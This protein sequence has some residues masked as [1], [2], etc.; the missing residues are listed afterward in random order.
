MGIADEQKEED[1]CLSKSLAEAYERGKKESDDKW[2]GLIKTATENSKKELAEAIERT[3]EEDLAEINKA[4]EVLRNLH[5]DLVGAP[6]KE[7]SGTI[8]EIV[9]IRDK[10]FSLRDKHLKEK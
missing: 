2:Q 6:K 10:V 5:K 3:R 1:K 4:L 7:I 9:R 8:I